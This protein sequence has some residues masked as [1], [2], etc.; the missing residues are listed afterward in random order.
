MR[1]ILV[2]V[3]GSRSSQRALD[4]AIRQANGSPTRV[5]LTYIQTIPDFY[6]NRKEYLRRPENK[7]LA[8]RLAKEAIAPAARKLT[9]AGV[10]HQTT[11]KWGDVASEIVRTATQSNSDAIVMGSRGRGL[12]KSLILGSTAMKVLQLSPVPITIVK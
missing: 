8:Q 1:T 5:L 11:V 4:Y 10:A 6:A 3:D 7:R 12:V 9:K 2:A